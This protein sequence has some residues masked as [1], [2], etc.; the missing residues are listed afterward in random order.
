MTEFWDRDGHPI[1]LHI[2]MHLYECGTYR[3]V[4]RDVAVSTVDTSRGLDISTIWQGFD[5]GL[6]H[7]FFS[8][9]WPE[10]GFLYETA[11]LETRIREGRK[12]L[13]TWHGMTEA[14]ARRNH[15]DATRWACGK[16]DTPTVVIRDHVI[17]PRPR[18]G[19]NVPARGERGPCPACRRRLQLTAAGTV[20]AHG[21][22]SMHTYPH[23]RGSR[24]RPTLRTLESR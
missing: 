10:H 21:R 12:I 17:P 8:P 24:L 23:C 6:R 2:W 15:D 22:D 9:D 5:T 20:V 1:N 18:A 4:A 13:E 19:W 7:L 11:V 3:T 14:D 16:L